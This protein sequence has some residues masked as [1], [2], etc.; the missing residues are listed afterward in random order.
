M[1]NC[2]WLTYNQDLFKGDDDHEGSGDLLV[3]GGEHITLGW[4]RSVCL[5]SNL[6]Y[7]QTKGKSI[8]QKKEILC[9]NILQY[10]TCSQLWSNSPCQ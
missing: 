2:S 4:V 6:F 8:Y 7:K 5:R 9:A 10:D 3:V 1:N